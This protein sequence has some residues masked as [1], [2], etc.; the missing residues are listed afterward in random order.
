MTRPKLTYFDAPASRGEECRLALHLSGV[1]FEDNRVK[2]ADWAAL[3]PQTPF[4]ALP[5]FEL[6]G[7]P[8]LA[9]TNAI[10]VLIGRMWGMH[11]KDNFEAARHEMM[12]HHVEDLRT[13][14]GRTL[15]MA[16]DDKKRARAAIAETTLPAWA[17]NGEKLIGEGPFFSGD[18]VNVV[19]VKLF[20]M[21][22]WLASGK[23]DHIPAE[24]IARYPKLMRVHD[25]VRDHA[26]V[27]AWYAR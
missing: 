3:K 19:D 2:Q 1:D 25:S 20:V 10:L 18:K 24:I 15:R 9:E 21:I 26:G 8:V 13:E 12:M 22:R 27:K 6:P 23:L 17:A 16:D 14:I 11:P 7:H 4:G 5:T